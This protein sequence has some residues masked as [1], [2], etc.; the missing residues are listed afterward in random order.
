MGVSPGLGF[1]HTGHERSFVYDIAD[2]YKVDI[3][4]PIAFAVAADEPDDVGGVTRR[5][6]RDAISDGRIMERT[7]RDI[8]SLLLPEK[9]DMGDDYEAD[10]DGDV[11]QLWD[12]RKES[13]AQGVSYGRE[14]D[15]EKPT[16]GNNVRLNDNSAYVIDRTECVVGKDDWADILGEGYGVILED[17]G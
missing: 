13:V 5:A 17:D 16:L 8:R 2:L 15:D 3:T 6:V 7:A 10:I 1:I 4:V 14:F 11:V 9:A 12:E